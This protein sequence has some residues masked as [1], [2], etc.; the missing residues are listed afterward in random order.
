MATDPKTGQEIVLVLQGGGALGSYQA[1]VYEVLSATGLDPAWI[2]GISIG[3]INAAILAGNSPERRIERLREFWEQVTS[4]L[5]WTPLLAGD[6]E[7]PLFTALSSTWAATFGVPGFFSPR[8]PSP[9]MSRAASVA[10]LSYYDTG[11]LR[12]TLERLIDFDRINAKKTRLSLGAVNV[13]TGNFI[14]F[15]N[16]RQKIGPE[17]IMASGAIPPGFPPI[18]IDGEYYWDGGIVSN[19]PIQYVL[20]SE[21]ERDL[22]IFQVD[23]FPARGDLPTT[24]M[25]A[26]EREKDIRFSSRT[27]M[28][29]DT[30]LKAHE[31]K[32][33]LRRLLD[34]LPDELKSLPEYCE[35]EAFT[36]ENAVTVVH[37]INRR[38]KSHSNAK[39]YEFSRLAMLEHWA[40]GSED[41]QMGLANRD[42]IRRRLPK[43]GLAVFDFGLGQVTYTRADGTQEIHEDNDGDGRMD[44][45]AGKD[46]KSR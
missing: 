39:D 3:G 11:P 34:R 4:T 37:F 45:I 22:L 2:A 31:V 20:D 25:A 32:T 35:A 5:P 44:G 28:N 18:E 16:T 10:H 13:Q 9:L 7:R 21:P 46:R 33:A 12:Q 38:R 8:L 41:A 15:D 6:G 36:R 43:C 14:Y 1:G 24:M 29:T 26:A 19:T 30:S 27:R 40:A 42:W 17:H 23:L